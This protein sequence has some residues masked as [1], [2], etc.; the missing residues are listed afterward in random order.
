MLAD[1][2]RRRMDEVDK[3]ID[4]AKS[5]AVTCRIADSYHTRLEKI[6]AR[7]EMS[8]TATAELLL[9]QSIDDAEGTLW[10]PEEAKAEPLMELVSRGLKPFA[11]N[12]RD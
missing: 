9:V 6:A 7:L 4:A 8:K 5:N 1:E 11:A 12:G 3:G 10:P 2:L